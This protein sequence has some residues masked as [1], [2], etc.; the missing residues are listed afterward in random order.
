[1]R[2]SKSIILAAL[3]MAS[4]GTNSRSFHQNEAMRLNQSQKPYTVN[5]NGKRTLKK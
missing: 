1:M 3:A 5:R 2:G 4:M